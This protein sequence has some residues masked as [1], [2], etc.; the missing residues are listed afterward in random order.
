MKKEH[1][2]FI[3]IAAIGIV[4]VVALLVITGSC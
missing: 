2:R 3:A 4:A 1:K